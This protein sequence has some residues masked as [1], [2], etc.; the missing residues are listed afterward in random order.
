MIE[1]HDD[2]PVLTSLH[3]TD[4][5]SVRIHSKASPSAKGWCHNARRGIEARSSEPV[6]I[7]DIRRMH[8]T[9][10]F[11]FKLHQN[12][13]DLDATTNQLMMLVVANEISGFRW[14]EALLRQKLAFEAWASIAGGVQVDAMPALDGRPAEGAAPGTE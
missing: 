9:D 14:D 5:Q 8:S 3:E 10:D 13:L 6:L 1:F 4:L 11:R 12:L 7:V 2:I